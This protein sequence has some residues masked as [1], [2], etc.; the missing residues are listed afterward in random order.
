LLRRTIS[1]QRFGFMTSAVLLDAAAQDQTGFRDATAEL[2]LV[3]V[4]HGSS[5]ENVLM[6]SIAGR[7]HCATLASVREIIPIQPATRLP[8][9]PGHVRGLINLRGNIVTVVDAAMCEYG[10]VADD[11]A[12]CILV[13]ERESGVAGV[14]VD[15]VHDMGLLEKDIS[16]DAL[17]DLR[18]M[19]QMALA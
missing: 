1:S 2:S 4:A 5:G 8:G 7:V 19:V 17:L 6:F 16:I 11:K 13:V 12:A 15:E 18:S 10:V 9:A 3:P 14:V